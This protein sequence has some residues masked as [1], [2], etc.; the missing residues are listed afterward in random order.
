MMQIAFTAKDLRLLSIQL[1]KFDQ[2]YTVAQIRSLDK[3]VTS[4]ELLLKDYSDGL[5]NLLN[6]KITGETDEEKQKSELELRKKLEDF[7][8]VEGNK[9]ISLMIEDEDLNFVRMFWSKLSNLNGNKDVRKAVIS[10][11]DALNNATKSIFVD[12]ENK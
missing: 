4:M 1:Q 12:K 9:K 2:G 11:D 6:E 10:I 8:E 3:V 7:V 5:N